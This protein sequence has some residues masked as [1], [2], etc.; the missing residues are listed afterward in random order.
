MIAL[1]SEYVDR[2]SI[3]LN[4]KILILTLPTVLHGKGAA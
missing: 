1:D 2:R 3:A 4:L